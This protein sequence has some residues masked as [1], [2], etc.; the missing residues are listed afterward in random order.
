VGFIGGVV[1]GNAGE[2]EAMAG[3][4]VLA[5]KAFLVD[6]GVP[7]F[8][9]S[10]ESV[11]RAA[12]RVLSRLGLPLMVHAESPGVIAR[13]GATGV[14]ERYQDYVATRPEDAETDAVRLL[15]RLAREYGVHVH[16]VHLSGRDAVSDLAA[17][18]RDGISVSAETCPH[19]LTFCA[20][21]IPDRATEFKCAPPIR[22]AMH[23]DA[24]W[25][26]LQS[27]T[28]GS[29]AS[30]HSPCPPALKGRERGDFAAAWGGIASLQLG[31]SVVWSG[32]H[33][34]GLTVASVVR[35]MCTAPADLAGL[36]RKGRIAVGADADLVLW[37][38]ELVWTVKAAE[39]E[40]RHALT[41][42]D[43]MT[44]RGR[45]VT[46]YVGGRVVYEDGTIHG[47]PSGCLLLGARP[48]PVAH[49]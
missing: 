19:Y 12:M 33:A 10:D 34:R 9:A 24:L 37:D 41:P 17:A 29:I 18:R 35:W 25:R 16:V 5:W 39:L 43:G 26:G 49:R 42:Y 30:D 4:G 7:E 15:I 36:S 3:A 32:A 23:R 11:L 46:T 44:V 6:S 21:E 48:A 8:A 45:A 2:L 1:P 31:L 22:G 13:A 20:E 14:V 40:H 27:G 28:I 38:P 47:P